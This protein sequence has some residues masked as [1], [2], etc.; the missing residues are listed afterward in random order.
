MSELAEAIRSGDAAKVGELAGRDPSLLSVAENGVTPLLLAIYHGKPEIARL[1]V[2]RGAPISFAEACA[3]GDEARA[4]EM[5]VADPS[6]L[7]SRTADG[8]PAVGV[9]IFFGHGAQRDARGSDGMTPADVA[10]K[11]GQPAFAEW[12]ERG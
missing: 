12:I 6:L 11:Y 1:L 10:R 5:L 9:A 8:F 2:E 4:K 7:H 3:M